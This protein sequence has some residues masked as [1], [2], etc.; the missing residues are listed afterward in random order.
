M[1]KSTIMYF[2]LPPNQPTNF[3]GPPSCGCDGITEFTDTLGVDL[4]GCVTLLINHT[5]SCLQ[6]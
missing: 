6:E 5:A 4:I 2:T 3:P 1:N